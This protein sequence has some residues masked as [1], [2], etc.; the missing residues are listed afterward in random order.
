MLFTLKPENAEDP[1]A[2][3]EQVVSF[4]ADGSGSVEESTRSRTKVDLSLGNWE[5]KAFKNKP[6]AIKPKRSKTGF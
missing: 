2:V 5:Q 4:A 6:A 1:E 3:I